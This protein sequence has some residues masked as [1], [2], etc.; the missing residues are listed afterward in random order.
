MAS[1]VGLHLN[2]HMSELMDRMFHRGS[3]HEYDFPSLALKYSLTTRETQL[4]EM[5]T[6]FW[7]NQEIASALNVRDTTLQKHFQNMFRKFNVTSRWEI[8]RLLTDS[9]LQR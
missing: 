4:L 6:H 7:S 1:S 9:D 3:E 5:M 2:Q 8:M